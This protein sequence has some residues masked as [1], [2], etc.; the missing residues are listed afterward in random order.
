MKNNKYRTKQ[1]KQ[2]DFNLEKLDAI[3]TVA[4]ISA[5]DCVFV[6]KRLY[7][8]TKQMLAVKNLTDKLKIKTY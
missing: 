8:L 1:E 3:I 2:H 6:P 4:I 5:Q 7:K